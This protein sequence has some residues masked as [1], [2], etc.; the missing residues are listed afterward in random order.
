MIDPRGDAL[1]D[2]PRGTKHFLEFTRP[3]DI[4]SENVCQQVKV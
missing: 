2:A 1:F 3:H 4:L